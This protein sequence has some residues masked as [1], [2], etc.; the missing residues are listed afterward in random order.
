M[1]PKKK[2]AK[3]RGR[4]WEFGGFRLKLWT[5][6]YRSMVHPGGINP[7]LVAFPPFRDSEFITQ[8]PIKNIYASKSIVK[9]P[10][11]LYFIHQTRTIPSAP[12]AE[13]FAN[14]RYS[15]V[16]HTDRKSRKKNLLPEKKK[17]SVPVVPSVA[18]SSKKKKFFLVGYG[19]A[20]SLTLFFFLAGGIVVY[21]VFKN[22]FSHV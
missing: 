17:R 12:T 22:I 2:C 11:P 16:P 20:F 14:F 9:S 5:R 21:C 6:V 1:P 13:Y 10:P 19:D 3:G 8:Q 18:K 7:S 4:S 15:I